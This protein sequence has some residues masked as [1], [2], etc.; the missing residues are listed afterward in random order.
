VGFWQIRKATAIEMGLEV[1]DEVDERYHLEK[2][3][4]AACG[5]LRQSYELYGSWTMAAAS[6]NLGRTG[7]NEQI[8]RQNQRYYYDLL[9]NQET[10]RYVYRLLALKLI[11]EN[12]K[13]YGFE[14]DS[15]EL[16]PPIPTYTVAVDTPV[17][18]FAAFAN[19]FAINYKVLKIFNPWLRDNKLSN[20]EG[21][22]YYIS[23]PEKGYRVFPVI[24]EERI[25][26]ENPDSIS[27]LQQ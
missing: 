5:F 25:G 9:L 18:D 13:A 15:S 23:I 8:E 2:S 1:N 3:T 21:K 17:R 7:L 6:Y 20:P 4:E 27:E 19:A 16:Y 11:L 12:P 24:D 10:G 26:T 22:T 14:F